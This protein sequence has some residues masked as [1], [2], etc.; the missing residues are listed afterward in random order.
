MKFAELERVA[1][2]LP[3][4]QRAALADKFPGSLSAPGV[5][6]SDEVVAL[7]ERELASGEVAAISHE[8][9]VRGVRRPRGR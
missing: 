4:R 6:F 1:L 7:R 8:E 2:R 9:F 3:E 5:D